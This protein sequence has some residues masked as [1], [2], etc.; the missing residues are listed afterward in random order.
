M[1][2][3][4]GGEDTVYKFEERLLD[5]LPI[6]HIEIIRFIRRGWPQHVEDLLLKPYFDRRF[7]F[8]VEYDC[9]LLRLRV[10]IPTRHQ[11]DM[12]EE[13]HTGH[14]G[15]VLMKKLARSHL[16]LPNVDLEIEQTM[17]NCGSC[18]QVRKAPAVAP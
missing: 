8:S 11:N 10:I 15:I 9:L 13:L 3:T 14:P 16:W 6:T 1:P 12:L 2:S 4:L 17:R 5:S 18:Q 7:E